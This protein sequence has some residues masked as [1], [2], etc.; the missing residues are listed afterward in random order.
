MPR[1]T[2]QAPAVDPRFRVPLRGVS[3]DDETRCL[4]GEEPVDVVALRFACCEGYYPCYAC[5]EATTDHEPRQWPR[6][7][8]DEPAVL[9]GV[10]RETLTAEHYLSGGNRCPHCGAAFNPSCREHRHLYFEQPDDS[11]P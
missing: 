10:C 3:V 1:R 7:R 9:C 6:A 2:T 8:F 11:P 5:H 4:H